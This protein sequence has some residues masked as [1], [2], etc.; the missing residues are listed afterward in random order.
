MKSYTVGELGAIAG[1]SRTA[2]LYYDAIGLLKPS[3]RSSS[4]YRLYSESDRA[5]LDRI[6][7]LRALGIPLGEAASLLALPD[8]EGAGALFKRLFAINEEIAALR[9][10]QRGI[11]GLL[12]T[13]L[14]PGR[15]RQSRRALESLGRGSGVGEHNYREIHAAFEASS[16]EEHRRLLGMLG[17]TEAEAGA[18]L[19]GLGKGEK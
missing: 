15:G 5:R 6:V 13:R 9:A 1:L 16:P 3:S 17:F 2:L 8:G 10:Q 18:F 12:E 19:A 11:L 4:G 7:A 14:P